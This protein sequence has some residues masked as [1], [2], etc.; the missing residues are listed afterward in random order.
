LVG[1]ANVVDD[2]GGAEGA[3]GVEGGDGACAIALSGT[4]AAAMMTSAMVVG[5]ATDDAELRRWRGGR[6]R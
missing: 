4:A 3:G 6:S 1:G 2:A 5:L